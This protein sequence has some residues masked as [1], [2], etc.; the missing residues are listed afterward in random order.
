MRRFGHGS[1][2][3]KLEAPCGDIAF[4]ARRFPMHGNHLSWRKRF[5]IALPLQ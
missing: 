5:N 1:L 4:G 3:T 2:R